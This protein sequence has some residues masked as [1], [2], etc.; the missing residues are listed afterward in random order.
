MKVQVVADHE[1]DQEIQGKTQ[2]KRLGCILRFQAP[3]LHSPGEENLPSKELL[4]VAHAPWGFSPPGAHRT[5]LADSAW[6]RGELPSRG[7]FHGGSEWHFGS[8]EDLSS[9]RIPLSPLL[10]AKPTKAAAVKNPNTLIHLR[11]ATNPTM[12][13]RTSCGLNRPIPRRQPAL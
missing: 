9:P 8:A 5:H 10:A 1:G 11:C 13:G 7:S 4:R 6:R 2:M 12:N 3:N